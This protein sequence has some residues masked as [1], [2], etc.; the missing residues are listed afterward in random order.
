LGSGSKG[1]ISAQSASAS[2]GLAMR[3]KPSLNNLGSRLC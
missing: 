3:A 1:S 2:R